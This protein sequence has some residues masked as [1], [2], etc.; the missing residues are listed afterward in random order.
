MVLI[1]IQW[2]YQGP[3]L[4]N[5]GIPQCTHDTPGLLKTPGR[6]TYDIPHCT[7]SIPLLYCTDVM[8]GGSKAID[9]I[10]S[11]TGQILQP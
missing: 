3:S 10:E 11:T 5:H 6:Y 2:F 7:H 9:P 4:I 1:Q 8:Q